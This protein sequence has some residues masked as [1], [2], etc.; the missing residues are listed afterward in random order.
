MMLES[1][2]GKS[3]FRLS[4]LGFLIGSILSIGSVVILR[5]DLGVGKTA[6][7][8]EI[9]SFFDFRDVVSPSFCILN[10]Y[11]THDF[12]INHFDLYRLKSEDELLGIGFEESLRV[13][14]TIVEWP[15]IASRFIPDSSLK[16]SMFFT[17]RD[18]IRFCKMSSSGAEHSVFVSQ[19]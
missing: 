15:E 1:F 12:T 7:S 4:D 9:L 13:G 19:K 16:I 8:K 14:I 11:K 10:Q 18:D 2:K 5:G 17:D 6:L 3:S